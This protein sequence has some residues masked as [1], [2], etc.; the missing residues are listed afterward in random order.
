MSQFIKQD[1]VFERKDQEIKDEVS[2]NVGLPEQFKDEE[3]I[4]E[5]IPTELE[6]KVTDHNRSKDSSD[7]FAGP[8]A[9]GDS[10]ST[11]K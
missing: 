2:Y 8:S 1:N 7:V 9:E 3:A 10:I 11:V 5:D 4:Y 6:E